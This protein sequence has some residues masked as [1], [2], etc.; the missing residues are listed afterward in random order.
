[1]R[2]IAIFVEGQSELIFTREL[3]LKCYEWQDI[4]VECYSLF[5]DNDLNPVEYSFPNPDAGFYYQILNI[6]NDNKV[7][8]S[9][10]KREKYL[11]SADQSFDKIIGL[12]DM[13]SKEYREA[14]RSQTIQN[15]VNQ[16]FIRS[17]ESTISEMAQ[18]PD[19]INFHFAIMELEAWLLGI[20]DIFP[21]FNEGL[22]TEK[23]KEELGVDL[24][25]L[26][27]EEEVFHP[28]KLISE[29]MALVA[30]G[31]DKKKGEVNKFMGRINK[32][33]FNVLFESNKCKT[34]KQFCN[35]LEIDT[36]T[37]KND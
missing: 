28:A 11:F 3:L 23:I 9:I 21:S 12:R 20:E 37:N 30:E 6:G 4:S 29:I 13:Y 33:D 7:L 25:E 1:M 26:D 19:K 27:P 36:T 34:F 22:T 10:L 32:E 31:Y 5:N 17:H 14:V 2:K 35:L 18:N 16:K 15:E 24:E 8:S